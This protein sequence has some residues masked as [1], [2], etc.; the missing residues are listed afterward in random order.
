MIRNSNNQSNIF[1]DMSLRNKVFSLTLILSFIIVIIF[2]YF[3]LSRW[4]KLSSNY[5]E[6]KGSTLVRTISPLILDYINAEDKEKITQLVKSLT[7]QE[8]SNNDIIS[9]QISDSS[10]T[11]I[12]EA[13]P[14]TKYRQSDYWYFPPTVVIE[15]ALV[16]KENAKEIGFIQIVFS[17]DYFVKK[18]TEVLEFSFIC[19]I[20]GFLFSIYVSDVV[21]RHINKPLLQLTNCINKV[22][23]GN[24]NI[25]AEIE[26]SNETL[27][28]CTAFS[29]VLNNFEDSQKKLVDKNKEQ[30]R[31]IYEISALKHI[32]HSLAL[33]HEIDEIYLKLVENVLNVLNGIQTCIVLL[34][35]E[36]HNEFEY[37]II[38]G[39]NPE[40]ITPNKR[41]PIESNIASK[42]Y[43][44]GESLVVNEILSRPSEGESDVSLQK[45]SNTDKYFYFPIIVKGKVVAILYG[46]N[47]ISG[48][49]FSESDL[50]LIEGII[51]ETSI[52][53]RNAML[54]QNLN[55]KVFEL[56]TLHEIAKNIGTVLDINKLLELILDHTES[57]F[58]GVQSS[59]IILYDEET[60]LLNVKLYKGKNLGR[61]MKPIK[62]GEGIAGKV[63]Q[64][65]EPIMVN[66][67]H[68]TD[69]NFSLDYGSSSICVPLKVKEKCLGVL[70]ITDK[71]SGEPFDKGDLD[72][73][74]TLA[75]QIAVSVNNAKL[76]EDLETSYLSAVRA[77][78]NSIDA[79]DTYTMGHSERV[80]KYSYEIGLKMNLQEEEL[81]TLYIG[82]LL[83]DIGKI[84]IPE[85]IINK[86]DKL[87]NEEYKEIKTH[88]TRGAMIIEPA[89]F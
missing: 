82:A 63:F 4:K 56:N 44:T 64:R 22:A 42:V 70:S 43:Q 9:V 40:S 62:S 37:K 12:A 30:E 38:K 69:K 24:Y 16:D 67:M 86:A 21:G 31:K 33:V 19:L 68:T 1:Y 35:D 58:G 89:K 34:V 45:Q 27:P 74:V 76:Y 79:K 17:N 59:S 77:L 61:E 50:R 3:E 49:N 25:E 28:L 85:S 78:A 5:T 10:K 72:M 46:K 66:D 29:T 15:K 14:N 18:S 71:L 2:T 81:K 88:P 11:K 53:L 80:A 57:I 7:T 23:E 65:C 83:H 8:V 32:N 52:A 6:E 84:G 13:A 55:Y 75:S 54:W 39:L 60:K 87:T 73:M 51:K 20:I 26:N 47:K 41:V 36:F 48:E